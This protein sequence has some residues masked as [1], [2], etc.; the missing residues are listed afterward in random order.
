MV[1]SRICP[2]TGFGF[3]LD[4]GFIGVEFQLRMQRHPAKEFRFRAAERG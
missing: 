2:G 1:T 4:F 3:L